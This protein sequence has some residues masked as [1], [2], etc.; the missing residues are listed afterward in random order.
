VS[1]PIAHRLSHEAHFTAGFVGR[2]AECARVSEFLARPGGILVVCGPPAMGKRTLVEQCLCDLTYGGHP[3][4]EPDGMLR[5]E[6]GARPVGVDILLA[7]AEFGLSAGVLAQPGTAAAALADLLAHRD[8]VLVLYDVDRALLDQDGVPVA[9]GRARTILTTTD[10]HVAQ[11]LC[12]DHGAERL[13]LEPLTDTECDAWLRTSR[14]TMDLVPVPG[15]EW[16]HWCR[17]VA[18][19]PLGLRLLVHA[20]W[21]DESGKAP[22]VDHLRLQLR[23]STGKRDADGLPDGVLVLASH[24]WEALDEKGRREV[25]RTGFAGEALHDI[26]PDEEA[27]DETEDPRQDAHESGLVVDVS[28]MHVLHPL[29]R[30]WLAR[31]ARAARIRTAVQRAVLLKC[32]RLAHWQEG[33]APEFSRPAA[34]MMEEFVGHRPAIAALVLRGTFNQWLQVGL[35]APCRRWAEALLLQSGQNTWDRAALAAVLGAAE[36]QLGNARAVDV[37]QFAVRQCE[38]LPPPNQTSWANEPDPD[39]EPDTL[40]DAPLTELPGDV[41]DAA[42]AACIQPWLLPVREAVLAGLHLDL[43]EALARTDPPAALPWLERGVLGFLASQPADQRPAR[44]LARMAH[45]LRQAGDARAKPVLQQARDAYADERN[46]KEDV[47]LLDLRIAWAHEDGENATGLTVQG[48]ALRALVERL[49]QFEYCEGIRGLRDAVLAETG[50][51]EHARRLAWRVLWDERGSRLN[52][53]VL[54]ELWRLAGD[55]EVV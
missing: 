28:G 30:P 48:A 11:V 44:N 55:V 21:K 41:S 19:L 51:A 49:P 43:A 33:L 23:A 25:L 18:H 20:L 37:L 10:P 27:D 29:L 42:L 24:A 40:E 3:D 2:V 15:V 9:V 32:L 39:V 35:A 46:L 26:E 6:C 5:L 14:R 13:D 31:L 16:K 34:A 8:V 53:N 1:D 45:V 12:R 52:D 36:L 7:A 54:A 17:A 47:N 50:D 4:V 38:R 22:D